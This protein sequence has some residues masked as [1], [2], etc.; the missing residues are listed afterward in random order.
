MLQATVEPPV[1]L[2]PAAFEQRDRQFEV[3]IFHREEQRARAFCRAFARNTARLHRR[4]HVSA[5]LEKHADDFGPSVP[6]GEEPGREARIQRRAEI[7][8]GVQQQLDNLC[9]TF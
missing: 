9:V 7:R 6:R 1:E 3:P 4:V 8:A 2:A 5:G